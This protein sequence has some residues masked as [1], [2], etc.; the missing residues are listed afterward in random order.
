MIESSSYGSACTVYLMPTVCFFNVAI[1]PLHSAA[2]FLKT[3]SVL[4]VFQ[5]FVSLRIAI[6]NVEQFDTAN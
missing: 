6:N 1:D 4:S 3:V 2:L 5:P